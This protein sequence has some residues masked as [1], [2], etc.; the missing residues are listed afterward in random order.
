MLIRIK[1]SNTNH[2]LTYGQLEINI[3]SIFAEYPDFSICLL[4]QV[5]AS[6]RQLFSIHNRS[7]KPFAVIGKLQREKGS[8]TGE[9]L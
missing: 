8:F 5:H 7:N 9:Q 4:Y 2:R 6:Y 1:A 3:I